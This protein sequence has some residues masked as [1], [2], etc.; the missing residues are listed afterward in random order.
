MTTLEQLKESIALHTSEV[1]IK[2]R[3]QQSI[4]NNINVF[5]QTNPYS[6]VHA[7][8]YFNSCSMSLL[9][10][11]SHT[12]KLIKCSFHCLEQIFKD[13]FHY[14]KAG[15][16]INDIQKKSGSQKDLFN[17]F[18]T[19]KEDEAM[20]SLDSI[21]ATHGKHTLKY[22]SLGIDRDWEIK[23]KMK[24]PNYTTRWSELLKI[25]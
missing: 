11:S 6:K 23:F 14:K 4:A 1:A 9:S 24:S 19:S 7:N 12:G 13:G 25:Q 22:A 20:R 8:Q 3:K 21:N 2:L 15:V 17:T 18:D 5:I 10:G 16:I